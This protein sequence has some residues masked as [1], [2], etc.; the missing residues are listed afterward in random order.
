MAVAMCGPLDSLSRQERRVLD[1]LTD[2]LDYQEIA[3]ELG[4][5]EGSARRLVSRLLSRLGVESRLEAVVL[6]LRGEIRHH[7]RPRS[8]KRDHN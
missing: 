1:L 5:E 3:D 2:A 4:I 7:N 6:V 8:Y